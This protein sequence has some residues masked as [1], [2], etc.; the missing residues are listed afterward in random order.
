MEGNN[1]LPLR[2]GKGRVDTDGGEVAL[3]EEG[4]ELGGTGN[5]LDEDTNLVELQVVEEVVQL[6]VL[7]L[8]LELEVVLL[9]T[10]KRELGLVVDV[11]LKRL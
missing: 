4:V 7:L 11:D 1:N 2:L 9:K 8:L 6:A 5:R 10:V 3:L